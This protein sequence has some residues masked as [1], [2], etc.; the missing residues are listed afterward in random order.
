MRARLSFIA[1]LLV[2][3]GCSRGR[4]ELSSLDYQTIDPPAP[5]ATSVP[6]RECYWWTD[7][8][9]AVRVAMRYV[10]NQPLF[11]QLRTE[12]NMSLV[13]EQPPRG[14]AR[15]YKLN[16][17]TL[18]AHVRMGPWQSRFT[19][20]VGIAALYRESGGRFRGS[21]RVQSMR[22]AARLLGGWGKPTRYLLQG[23]FTAINDERRG[24]EIL[25]ITESDGWE[26]KQT[27]TEQAGSADQ[28]P[29]PTD[30]PP[31]T[32]PRTP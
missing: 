1:F 4:I 15:N 9:G 8:D 29:E 12:F 14:Q 31:A 27:A 16:R 6:L 3:V 13:L 20:T 18:R 19:S 2:T 24:R 25:E 11:P 30:A 5:G 23:S 17:Q 22:V 28:V 26:R 21:L 32:I 10:K 7:E